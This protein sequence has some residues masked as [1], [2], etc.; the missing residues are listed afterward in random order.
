[1]TRVEIMGRMDPNSLNAFFSI[2]DD[3]L[4]LS[5]KQKIVYNEIMAK[6]S[7]NEELSHKLG[8]SINKITPR[9]G[10]LKKMN[11]I[12]KYYAKPTNSGKMANVYGIVRRYAL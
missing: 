1:M 2:V 9:T 3:P 12:T 4:E 10:E 8:W 5:K 6:P 7:T 11:L